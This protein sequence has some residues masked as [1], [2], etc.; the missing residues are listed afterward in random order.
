[1]SMI[2][3]SVTGPNLDMDKVFL[4]ERENLQLMF[5]EG[6][7]DT[8]EKRILKSHGYELEKTISIRN[9]KENEIKGH[10][11]FINLPIYMGLY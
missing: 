5:Y 11:D 7:L 9:T 8:V 4:S 2:D 10:D 3:M 1:M 6:T